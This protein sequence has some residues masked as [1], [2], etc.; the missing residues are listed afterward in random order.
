MSPRDRSSRP[1]V[2]RPRSRF[3]WPALALPGAVWLLLLFVAPLYVVL[4]IVF[5]GVDPIFRTPVP[6][7][8]PVEWNTAQF[9]DVF[10]HIFG[11]D[12]YFGPALVRTA[13]YVLSASALCLLIAYPVAYYVARYGGRWRKLVLALL[14]APFWISYMMRMLAWVNLLQND[15]L[16]NRGLRLGGLEPF[17][18]DWLDGRGFVVVLGLVY[19]Y[20]PYMIL[21][22]YVGLDRLPANVARSGPGPRGG[23]VR[24][25]PAGDPAALDAGRHRRPPAD[26]PADARRLLH[27]RPAVGLPAHRDGRQPHQHHRAHAGA[28]RAGRCLRAARAGGRA[29]P[30]AALRAQRPRRGAVVVNALSRWWQDPRRRPRGLQAI[31]IGYLVWSLLPVLIAVVFSFNAGRSRTLWQGFSF[32]WYWGDPERSVWH[33]AT[34]HTALTHTL[35]LGVLATAITVPLGVA[36]ALGLDRW[37]GRIP[38]GANIVML[39]SFVIPETLLAVAL[40]FVVTQLATPLTLGTSAQVAGL[41]TFQLSYPVIIV[42]ARLMT[43]GK[44]YEQAAIDLGCSPMAAIR[45]VLLPMLMPAIFASAVLVFADVIDDFVIVRYLS[46]DASTEPTSVKIY[47]TARAAPTPALNA[48]ASLMLLASFL[49]VIVGLLAYRR[50]R[51]GEKNV[52]SIESF[53]GGL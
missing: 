2:R 45:R 13:V 3:L 4:A 8:N 47:N 5:G 51:R 28:D 38:E 31:T 11:D 43:I 17:A 40:L 42:R 33:D 15:G 25:L 52:S 53:A 19:G 1:R 26:L 10:R 50:L 12:G 30:D 7:W 34:M 16:V 32:R 21:P 20:V 44:Q 9:S 23:S 46:G 37:R 18:I 14:I 36:F 49:A 35:L 24:H 22:L 29:G 48:L 27:L 41:V 39:F 6:V